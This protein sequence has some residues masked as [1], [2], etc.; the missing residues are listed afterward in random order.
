MGTS[1]AARKALSRPPDYSQ[2]TK[3][4]GI[5]Q[6]LENEADRQTDSQTAAYGGWCLELRQ[7]RWWGKRVYEDIICYGA[8]FS[9]WSE[10]AVV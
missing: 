10:R 4:I 1:T 9:V 3:S 2:A 7:R 5:G 6:D 8:V